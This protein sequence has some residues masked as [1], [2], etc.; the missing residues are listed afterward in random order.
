[1]PEAPTRSRLTRCLTIVFLSAT[2]LLAFTSC[3]TEKSRTALISDP[4]SRNESN[5]PWNKPARWETGAN[6]PGGIG[7]GSG[8]PGSPGDP[9]Y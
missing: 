8:S 7:G 2:G 4:D 5:I 1:M 6:V 9:G 3:A